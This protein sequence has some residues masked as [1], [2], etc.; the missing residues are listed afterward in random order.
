MK[1][2]TTFFPYLLSLPSSRNNKKIIK[3][4]TC[5]CAYKAYCRKSSK[6]VLYL[7]MNTVRSEAH[8]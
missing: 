1:I 3:I 6:L 5:L 8:P 4:K 7:V 2:T